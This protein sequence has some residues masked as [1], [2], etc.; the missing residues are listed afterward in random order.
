[1]HSSSEGTLTHAPISFS[2][3]DEIHHLEEG[4]NLLKKCW[5]AFAPTDMH[6]WEQRISN[7]G[8]YIAAAYLGGAIAGMLEGIRLDLGGKP[9]SVPPTFQELTANGTWKNHNPDGDTLVLVDL[10]VAPECRGAGLFEAF[11]RFA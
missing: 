6:A 3:G 10:T 8:G 11:V 5:K 4:L 7:S 1:M 2:C 9:S